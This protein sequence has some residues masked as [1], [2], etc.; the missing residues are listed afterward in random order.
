MHI[1]PR[2]L[3]KPVVANLV[4]FELNLKNI[5]TIQ[6]KTASLITSWIF[7]VKILKGLIKIFN[8]MII[9]VQ[10]RT[11][12]TWSVPLFPINN[13]MNTIKTLRNRKI[14]F[15]SSQ[16]L[17]FLKQNQFRSHAFTELALKSF[18]STLN[19]DFLSCSSS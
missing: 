1:I 7:L 15:S 2:I 11:I 5:V 6:I 13:V 4:E 12:R 16:R 8:V 10:E 9:S 3:A 19:L 18:R 14:T 17:N